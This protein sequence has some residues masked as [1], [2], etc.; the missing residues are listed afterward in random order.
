MEDIS[1]RTSKVIRGNLCDMREQKL[2]PTDIK[3]TGQA[4]YRERRKTYPDNP[5]A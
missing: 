4:L 2:R 3:S 5:K 1:S